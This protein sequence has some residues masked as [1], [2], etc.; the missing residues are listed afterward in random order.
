MA[1]A[2]LRRRS[3]RGSPSAAKAEAGPAVQ[4]TVRSKRKQAWS[5]SFTDVAETVKAAGQ[6]VLAQQSVDPRE[7]LDLAFDAIFVRTFADRRI[8]YWNRAAEAIYGFTEREALGRIPSELL[9]SE[10]PI[11]LVEIERTLAETGRWEGVIIHYH[12][13]GHQVVVNGRWALKRDKR[14]QPEA[15][16]EINSDVTAE[17][18]ARQRLGVSE[19]R[20]KLLVE[21]VQDYA[22]F[23]LDPAGYILS[24]NAGAQRIKGYT[25]DEAIGQ[26]FSIFYPP[27]EIAADKPGK[28]L[29]TARSVGRLEDEG[30]RLRKDGSRFWA[31]VVIT[32]LYDSEGKLRGFAKVTRDLTERKRI[33]DEIVELRT[34]E[35]AQ[36][37]EQARKATELERAKSRLLNLASH[38]L[39]GPL[40]VLRG[41]VSMIADGTIKPDQI[42]AVIPILVAKATQMNSLVQ[43]MLES[44]RLEDSRMQLVTRPVDLRSVVARALEEWTPLVPAGQAIEVF[45]AETPV[46]TE[47]DAGR[48]QTIVANLL[49]NA[50]KYSLGQGPIV[51]SVDSADSRARVRV[52]DSGPGI[53]AEHMERLFGRFERIVTEQNQHI[54]GTGLGLHLAREL[55]RLHDGDLT[56]V[57]SPGKGSEFTLTL[58]LSD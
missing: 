11:P 7:L 17:Y 42:E 20:F 55:A 41:Y 31:N 3:P 25:A 9:G 22:I 30:W 50:I 2:R 35:A 48:V 46:R 5:L 27:E 53:S 29:V 58:P 34:R 15:I 26:H 6:P 38:E 4:L 36:L 23:M 39:R 8:I 14:E 18:Q 1:V 52:R 21:A 28:E 47:I 16:L 13:D 54:A 10:Y 12:R 32:A 19:E 49:D 24:W 44:A 45:L 43:Q 57:S 40:A 37:A 56:A 51:V 33:Q